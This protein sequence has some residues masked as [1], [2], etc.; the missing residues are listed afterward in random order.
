MSPQQTQLGHETGSGGSSDASG[1]NVGGVDT[2][3]RVSAQEVQQ[4]QNLIERCMQQ[5]LPQAQVVSILQ[6]QAKIEPSFS[7]LV[8]Q[9]LEEQNPEFFRMYSMRLKLKEQIVMFNYLLEQQAT[10]MQKLYTSWLQSMPAMMGAPPPG[11]AAAAASG[12]RPPSPMPM[13]PFPGMM[14]G[15]GMHPGMGLPPG[16]IPPGMG[17]PPSMPPMPMPPQCQGVPC[18]I[19]RFLGHGGIMGEEGGD[20]RMRGLGVTG[21]DLSFGELTGLVDFETPLEAGH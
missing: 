18:L 16:M 20:E 4:V 7:N 14:P 11:A 1:Q 17:M 10:M 3:K 6:Q 21:R 8:W 12:A 15:M 13:F 5:Y 19:G 9:K 2:S